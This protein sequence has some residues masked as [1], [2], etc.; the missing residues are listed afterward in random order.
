MTHLYHVFIATMGLTLGL[1]LPR[2]KVQSS[3]PSN[4]AGGALK[5]NAARDS[6]YAPIA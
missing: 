6:M 1:G 2:G 3:T 4:P 5:F